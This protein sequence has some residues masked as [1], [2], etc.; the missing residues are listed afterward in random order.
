MLGHWLLLM[1]S[2]PGCLSMPKRVLMHFR[3]CLRSSIG[4]Q[5]I[6]DMLVNEKWHEVQSRI[7]VI[8]RF[9]YAI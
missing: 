2:L 9:E 1:V 4:S 5:R 3:P 8:A 6:T 7:T